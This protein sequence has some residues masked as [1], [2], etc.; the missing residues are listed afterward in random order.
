[1]DLSEKRRIAEIDRTEHI[2]QSYIFN[3][4]GLV[5]VDVDWHVPRWSVEGSG[6]HSVERKL[7]EWDIYLTDECVLWGAF[8]DETLVGFSG[9]RP[10]LTED[11]GQFGLLHISSGYRRLGIGKLL[12]GHVIR[13]SRQEGDKRLYVT[14][15]PSR[16]TVDF[17]TGL[18]F[19]PTNRPVPELLEMEPDDIHM[20]MDLTASNHALQSNTCGV[21]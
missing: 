15:T 2:I 8:D 3:E 1:M 10:G 6:P 12:S 21:R 4:R 16:A 7:K 17:Y 14:A 19:N 5:L 9:Y 11:M 18:G 20:V 13:R